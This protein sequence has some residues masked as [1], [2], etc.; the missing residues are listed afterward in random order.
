[1]TSL[2]PIKSADRISDLPEELSLAILDHLVLRPYLIRASH[3]SRHWRMLAYSHPTFWR[4][5]DISDKDQNASASSILGLAIAQLQSS[6]I[7][8]IRVNINIA[9]VRGWHNVSISFRAHAEK[10]ASSGSTDS[11]DII[12][13]FCSI[14]IQ[15]LH[16]ISLLLIA[17]PHVVLVTLA[18]H[19]L[20]ATAAPQL[21]ALTLSVLNRSEDIH[22]FLFHWSFITLMP[23]LRSLRLRGVDT[24]PIFISK[25]SLIY[26]HNEVQ[27]ILLQQPSCK[28]SVPGSGLDELLERF[29]KLHT[30][31]LF[32][33]STT[34]ITTRT[35]MSSQLARFRCITLPGTLMAQLDITQLSQVPYLR[36][37]HP[38]RVMQLVL[39]HLLDTRSAGSSSGMDLPTLPPLS[40]DLQ[41]H[42]TDWADCPL[43][44]IELVPNGR[45]R[46]FDINNSIFPPGIA[47]FHSL[48]L[49]VTRLAVPMIELD[50]FF[51]AL[52]GAPALKELVLRIHSPN[53]LNLECPFESL[54]NLLRVGLEY[55]YYS[56]PWLA[57]SVI[58]IVTLAKRVLAP[59]LYGHARL[60][61]SGITWEE[62]IETVQEQLGVYFARVDSGTY[63]WNLQRGLE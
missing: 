49:R 26:P 8:R 30:I 15:N 24:V 38:T 62:P 42:G 59:E 17:A 11:A 52:D 27:E 20:F 48:A 32:N 18:H 46:E 29:P 56:N 6:Q 21:E 34:S 12:T 9:A 2:L 44:V 45:R 47:A 55:A 23:K 63:C 58:K 37:D 19:S 13:E 61:L 36:V 1:M 50:E 16:R 39:E 41:T 5:V 35:Q 54:P 51:E 57:V 60:E 22:L 7:P 33:I 43:R 40:I 53:S 10:R 25:G 3:L 4:N 14:L 31:Q 28:A